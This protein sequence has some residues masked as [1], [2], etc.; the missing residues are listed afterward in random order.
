MRSK[1]A[2]LSAIFG[3]QMKSKADPKRNWMMELAQAG[4]ESAEA[5]CQFLGPDDRPRD[6]FPLPGS[7]ERIEW[8]AYWSDDKLVFVKLLEDVL[9]RKLAVLR[10]ANGKLILQCFDCIN[11]FFNRP[12]RELDGFFR[13]LQVRFFIRVY[14]TCLAKTFRR[15]GTVLA[16]IVET[17]NIELLES[18]V[19]I[20]PTI[21]HHPDLSKLLYPSS[22]AV[23]RARWE[24]LHEA[25]TKPHNDVE[26]R[27]VKY[28][29]AALL[30]RITRL[31]G[32]KLTFRTLIRMYNE[33]AVAD[34]LGSQDPDLLDDPATFERGVRRFGSNLPY[35]C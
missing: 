22:S 33:V 8:L 27:T 18:V 6:A 30:R 5:A 26:R 19:R 21:L 13:S 28:G 17:E 12:S 15:P 29:I 9:G 16:T 1:E 24:L 20:D 4:V 3:K 14:L 34:G 23:R 10:P 7:D 11:R 25:L 2:V 32:S 31:S 35:C